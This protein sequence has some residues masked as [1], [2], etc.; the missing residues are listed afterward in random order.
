MAWDSPSPQSVRW[1][2]E[3][4]V[5]KEAVCSFMW[6][7]CAKIDP[8]VFPSLPSCTAAFAVAILVF[9]AGAVFR[10]YVKFPPGGSPFTRIWRVFRGGIANRKLAARPPAELY[11]PPPGVDGALPFLM[12]HTPRM[13]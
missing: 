7:E 10:L 9:I 4:T 12:A 5:Q 6:C 3:S 13:K 2:R 11:Q 8:A 1:L